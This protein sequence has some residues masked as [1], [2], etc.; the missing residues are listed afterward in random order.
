MASS[1][2]A[3][4]P[5]PAEHPFLP[6]LGFVVVFCAIEAVVMA[7]LYGFARSGLETDRIAI[8]GLLPMAFAVISAGFA[9]LKWSA[10]RQSAPLIAA[11]AAI[12]MLLLPTLGLLVGAWILLPLSLFA[13]IGLVLAIAASAE[14]LRAHPFAL[15]LG[16]PA[17]ALVRF[18]AINGGQMTHIYAPEFMLLGQPYLDTSFH[19]ALTEMLR[20]F[21]VVSV[22]LDGLVPQFH[23]VGSHFWLGAVSGIFDMPAIELYP[24]AFQIFAVPCFTF[25]FLYAAAYLMRE[26]LRNPVTLITAGL[27]LTFVT[28]WFF[29]DKLLLSESYLYSLILFLAALPLLLAMLSRAETSTVVFWRFFCAS[30]LFGAILIVFKVPTGVMWAAAVAIVFVRRFTAPRWRNTGLVLGVLTIA[31]AAAILLAV[32][33]LSK[34]GV[35]YYVSPFDF[36]GGSKKYFISDVLFGALMALAVGLS[37]FNGSYARG[38]AAGLLGIFVFLGALPGSIFALLNT[39]YYFVNITSWLALVL[40]AGQFAAIIEKAAGRR[41]LIGA[42]AIVLL[43]GVVIADPDRYK[44]FA[45]YLQRVAA[46]QEYGRDGD[47]AEWPRKRSLSASLATIGDV[48][49]SVAGRA[50][51]LEPL[52]PDEV[53]AALARSPGGVFVQQVNEAQDAASGRLAVFVPPHNA[54]FWNMTRDCRAQPFFIPAMTGV[55][56]LM[57]LAPQLRTLHCKL[58]A[59]YGFGQYGTGSHSLRIED[60]L[61]CNQARQRGFDS[62]MILEAPEGVADSRTIICPP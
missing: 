8:L 23:H 11:F 60:G 62:V 35:L 50:L 47:V 3:A 31:G 6:L 22:G 15:I 37:R 30:I 10:G 46:L 4:S 53:A 9:A 32:S 51:R 29:L 56:M 34:H 16:A 19:A 55:P 21:G 42:A 39:A 14:H 5:S 43:V 40:A 44:R 24:M 2:A 48:G 49:S 41:R 25:Y 52:F 1:S 26:R 12:G 33:F 59:T 17:F 27:I 57:G 45:I 20:N 58:D 38:D 54:A 7:A 13:A 36:A 28:S 61:L 18:I